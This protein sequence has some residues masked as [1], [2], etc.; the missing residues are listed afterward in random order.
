MTPAALLAAAA[1]LVPHGVPVEPPGAGES[2]VP[3]PERVAALVDALSAPSRS[4]RALAERVLIALGPAAAD[5]LPTP[6]S[7]AAPTGAAALA[8]LDRVR[9]ALAAPPPLPAGPSRLRIAELP[10]GSLGALLEAIA[11]RTGNRLE[12]SELEPGMLSAAA[13]DLSTLAEPD[14]TVTFWTALN[15]LAP[16]RFTVG[17]VGEEGLALL[18]PAEAEGAPAATAAGVLRIEVGPVAVRRRF[19]AEGSLWRAPVRLI[20]EPRLQP[21]TARPLEGGLKATVGG[22]PLEP[23][24]PAAS[25]EAQFTDGAT[26]FAVDFL[27][28]SEGS[29]AADLAALTFGGAYEATFL[30]GRRAFHFAPNAAGESQ[31]ADGVT[32][33]LER[34]TMSP[35]DAAIAAAVLYDADAGGPAF[36][37]YQTWR[38]E[39][40][41][42]LRTAD[43]TTLE[44]TAPP[45]VVAEGSAA[46]AV[47]ASFSLP[48]DAAPDRVEIAA[49]AAPVTTA[50]RFEALNVLGGSTAKETAPPTP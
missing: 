24:S 40:A 1:M 41:V 8:A 11:E 45:R 31:S 22:E 17:T 34:V 20:A 15:A 43:G 14:G 23:F 47:R 37:S 7:P 12:A 48:A 3:T 42:R 49:P 4:E 30:P 27:P 9:T 2:A 10:R 35:V 28:P 38:Y 46:V 33:R 32:V 29:P 50:V 44:P 16:G 18:P 26:T 39:V 6:G 5:L 13:P 25:R 19:G 21:L 36:E